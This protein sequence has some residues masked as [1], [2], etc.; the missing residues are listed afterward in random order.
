MRRGVRLGFVLDSSEIRNDILVP[1]YYDPAIDERLQELSQSHDLVS[2]GALIDSGQLELTQGDYIGK[3]NYGTGPIPYIRTSDLANWELRSSPKHG[4]AEKIYLQYKAKQD[5]QPGDIL[6]VHEGTYL[7]GTACLLT[8]FDT[9]IILQ[10]HLAK[11]RLTDSSEIAP[12][13]LMACLLSPIVEAQIRARQF[14]ADIIDSIVGR[15]PEVLVP[16]PR[17]QEL[18]MAI[19]NATA[20]VFEGRAESRLRL[21]AI[22]K[23]ADAFLKRGEVDIAERLASGF[24]GEDTSTVSLLGDRPPRTSFALDTNRIRNDVLVPHYYDPGI[25]IQLDEFRDRCELVDIATLEA[26]GVLEIQTGHEVGKLS[27]GT[28]DIPFVR[29]SDLGNWELK[30]DPKQRVGEDIFDE[31][32]SKQDVRHGDVLM[33]R[34]GTYLVGTSVL[35]TEIDL[36][37]LYSAGIF[38]IRSND[39]ERLPPELLLLLLNTRIVWRQIQSKRFTRDVIDT[40]GNRL[41]E[42][43]LPIPKESKD[44]EW[45]KEIMGKELDRR[46][47]LRR[48]ARDLG[49]ALE[50]PDWDSEGVAPPPVE[51]SIQELTR[52]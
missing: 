37:M 7:I 31:Y 11:I 52:A 22:V 5:V 15:L 3:I 45:L 16:I 13:L 10:H 49:E 32:N 41:L 23:H 1:R 6:L 51:R 24:D 9:K 17:N 47:D 30:D 14:T 50:R 33:V 35:V 29:T 27:Y 44:R 19:S 20:R 21:A 36:P 46:M 2:L 48:W 28:G 43:T 39:H 40:I 18:S 34:D 8:E 4:V 25:P 12:A 38:R 26:E 42:V